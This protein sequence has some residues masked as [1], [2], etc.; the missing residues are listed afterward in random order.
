MLYGEK[1]KVGD[2]WE[3]AITHRHAVDASQPLPLCAFGD[4]TPPVM[5]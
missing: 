3:A 5:T 2:T 1:M 4:I